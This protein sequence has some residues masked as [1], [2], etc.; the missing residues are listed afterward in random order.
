ML[1]A[2]IGVEHGKI[3][4]RRVLPSDGQG[5]KMEVTF[6]ARGTFVGIDASGVGTYWTVV[7]A[8]GALYGEGEGLITTDQGDLVQWTGTG[9]GRLTKQGGASFRGAIY[10]R[11]ASAKLGHVNE[12]AGVYEHETD[13]DGNV[14]TKTWEWK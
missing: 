6:E 14:T 10:F 5:P 11:T 3:T 7:Q 2:Q 13:R 9:R 12:V 1:G 8:N 4:G